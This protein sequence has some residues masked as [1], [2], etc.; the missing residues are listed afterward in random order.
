MQYLLLVR[1]RPRLRA[2]LR[3]AAQGLLALLD[4]ADAAYGEEDGYGKL[5]ALTEA[6]DWLLRPSGPDDSDP[7]VALIWERQ[8]DHA[9]DWQSLIEAL[10]R[11]GSTQW[12]WAIQRCRS[13]MRFEAEMGIDLAKLAGVPTS[14][15]P[16]AKTER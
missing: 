12:Q 10:H 15:S 5:R 4:T 6:P 1:D 14:M 7:D 11:T 13:L 8:I 16:G 3:R 9:G 2:A